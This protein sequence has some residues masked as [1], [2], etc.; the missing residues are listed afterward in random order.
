MLAG[1]VREN[2]E[3][4]FTQRAGS[5][6][7]VDREAAA[8]LLSRVGLGNLPLDREIRTV[9]G[10]ERHRIALVR[11]LLWSPPV[12]VADEPISGL[13]PEAEEACF[14]LLLEFARRQGNLVICVVHDPGLNARSDR[15]LRLAGGRLEEIS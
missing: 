12:L 6:R 15:K 4:P 8:D 14:E 9:S 3:L 13:D 1:T 5:G 7:D 10:G 11:G 2:L